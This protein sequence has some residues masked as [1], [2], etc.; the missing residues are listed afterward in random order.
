[1]L[2]GKL[3]YAGA[4]PCFHSCLSLLIVMQT[5]FYHAGIVLPNPLWQALEE[6]N[7]IPAVVIPSVPAPNFHE[8]NQVYFTSDNIQ[9]QTYLSPPKVVEIFFWFGMGRRKELVFT[10]STEGSWWPM[11]SACPCERAQGGIR[12][13]TSRVSK[14]PARRCTITALKWC[15]AGRNPV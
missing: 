4:A 3:L 6:N 14:T 5:Q 11:S 10:E 12:A 7:G 2:N 8:G 9:V 1:M 13:L 15:F